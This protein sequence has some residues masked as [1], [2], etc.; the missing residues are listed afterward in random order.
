MMDAT[1]LISRYGLD[2][3]V[4]V[5]SGASGNIGGECARELAAL[6]AT[7]IAGYNSSEKAVTKLAEEVA[8]AG[9]TL[10][11]VQADLLTPGGPQTL[12]DAALDGYGKIDIC[13]CAA[14]NRLRR[15]ATVTTAEA[16]DELLTVNLRSALAMAK[17]SLRPMM[18]AKYG[19][20]IL[21][22]SRA[23]VTGLPGHAAYAATKG[24]LQPW[25]A[26]VAG[27]LGP[28]GVT[29]NV[30]APGAIAAEETEYHSADEQD[31]VKKFIGAGRFGEP[32]EVAA[33]VAFLASA[34]ASYV[35]GSTVTVDGGARF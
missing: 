34:S 27:E 26:S 8:A 23:G 1:H 24:A 20:I 35:N 6:G 17:A 11:P 30:V 9:G 15:L 5:V 12:I 16:V 18:R 19:R 22:G 14:G 33:A 21:F 7:V 2:G 28:Y 4:A 3:R 29:V 31:L 32:T 25:A 13:V 10:I